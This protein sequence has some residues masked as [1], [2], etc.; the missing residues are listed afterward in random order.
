[1][2]DIDWRYRYSILYKKQKMSTNN[3]P[4]FRLK[5]IAEFLDGEHHFNIP[6]YQRGY[7]WDKK[8]VEDLCKDIWD[9]ARDAQNGDFYCLQPIVVKEKDWEKNGKKINGWEVID[10]QQ[11]LTTILLYL[12]YLRNNSD[13]A[14]N[15]NAAFYDI[16]YET[17]PE[18]NFNKID[19]KD[20]IDS[21][22]AYN[23]NEVIR[24]WF[25][26]NQ[27]KKSKIVEVLF[28]QYEEEVNKK[29]EPQVKFIWYVVTNDNDIKSIKTFNNLNKGKI[30]LTNAELIKALFILKSQ[31]EKDKKKTEHLNINELAY[32]W[33]EIEN[34]LHNNSFW[35][36]IAN[37]DY[38]PSTRID[39]IF[40]FLTEKQSTSDSDYSYRKFQDLFDNPKTE[41]W[42]NKDILNFTQAWEAVKKVH[43]T[44]VYWNEN[45]T[46]YHYVGYLVACGV[47]LKVIFNNCN[48]K[49]KTQVTLALRSLIYDKILKNIDFNELVYDK[50]YDH[51]KNTLLLF[52]IESCIVQQELHEGAYYRFPFDLFKLYD[53]DIE[54]VD[55]QTENPLTEVKDKIVWLSY[56]DNLDCDKDLKQS[57]FELKK[58]LKEKKKDIGYKF[59]GLYKK[60]LSVVQSENKTKEAEDNDSIENL[61]L[62][63]A[64]TNRGYGNA[65]FPTKRKTIIEKDRNGIFIPPCTKNLFL[66]YYT[67]NDKSN[68]QWKNNWTQTD[69]KAYLKAIHETI[70]Y[71]F[72]V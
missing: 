28:D 4:N 60:V 17:R 25:E 31:E 63:D 34:T 40:D 16:N 53:W 13:D 30:S 3:N 36:F 47:S 66:K 22:Y 41:F 72:K 2:N 1:M 37:K 48:G 58:V 26:N 69:K 29:T 38:N 65:L 15:S 7:R 32:E 42:E 24:K 67:K 52:N 20:D 33:N 44:L 19:Y 35:Y 71:L 61:T 56:I 70:D 9:F 12:I 21:F 49:S 64:G 57:C 46:L 18:L 55:S 62:L 5:P 50:R 43:Q 54:H 6:S 68:T 14:K 23:A 45:S 59:G 39:I 8:Q 27:V 51:C 10:G 11:R